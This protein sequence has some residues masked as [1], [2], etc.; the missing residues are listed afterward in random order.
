MIAGIR[1]VKSSK[2]DCV[3]IGVAAKWAHRTEVAIAGAAHV[4]TV[5]YRFATPVDL[6]LIAVS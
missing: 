5:D 6:G 1:R 4:S 3:E 2:I